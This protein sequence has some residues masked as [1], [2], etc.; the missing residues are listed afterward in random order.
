M[1]K[2]HSSKIMIIGI[3]GM[4]P[5]LTKK[6]MEQGLMPHTQELLRRGAGREDLTMLGGHP[7]ITPPMWTTMA[8]GCY[9]NVHGITC[10]FRESDN[11]LHVHKGYNLH[12]GFCQAELLWNCFVE[13]G[14]K[15]LVYHW[16]G[17]SWPPTSDSPLLHVI[18]GTQP[19][20]VN[21]GIAQVEPEFI[22]QAHVDSTEITF[23][24]KAASDEHIPCVTT[25]MKISETAD[26][27]SNLHDGTLALSV[28]SDGMIDIP[29]TWE[30]GSVI[31]SD[32]PYDV[33][34][35]TLKDASGWSNPIASDAKEFVLLLSH[36]LLR[37]NCLLL[38][39]E[40][41]I[42]DQVAIYKNK[43][44]EEPMIIL[45]NDEYT[46]EI[47]DE[48]IVEDERIQVN[49]N[50]RVLAIDP[51]GNS[52]KIWVSA[53]MKLNED[54]LFHPKKL[55]NIVVD[56]AGNCPPICNIGAGSEKL[57][58][59]CMLKTWDSVNTWNSRAIHAL[60]EAED[61][62]M[63][64]TQMHNIDAV[65]HM[66]LRY[67]N[68]R[69]NSPLPE[70]KYQ[71]LMQQCY[72]DTDKYIGS[73]LHFLDEGWTLFLVSD[74]AQVSSENE[75]VFVNGNGILAELGYAVLKKDENG[76]LL[77]EMDYTQSRA[78]ANRSGHIYISLKGREPYGIV[79]PQD[80]YELEEQ[81]I[82]D[83]YSYRDKKTGKRVI[84]VALRKRDA[85]WF[86][87]GGDYPQSGD[88][89]YFHAEGYNGDHGDCLS[90]S[91]GH[92]DTSVGPI[93]I[94]AGQGIKKN[95][96]TTRIIR[97]IDLVPTIAVLAGVRMPAQT[98]GAPIYQILEE[99]IS[100]L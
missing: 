22:L 63:A 95:T 94:A 84:S 40:A 92:A 82:S 10:Y 50:M 75:R 19:A 20:G 8:T 77:H 38:K 80:Q 18:D 39:N 44:A 36:G 9:A 70:E 15:T 93:F 4:D 14:K 81:I 30:E 57:I 48:A 85:V 12:S 58:R 67:M 16:P 33:V 69:F 1:L 43:K 51:K 59:D 11:L 42:Y 60:I 17:S 2:N 24:A 28:D 31:L 83:L 76:N 29:L 34:I 62:E 41:G 47:I 65:G 49:R 96:L 54:A 100:Q 26:A 25:G 7:T 5:R 74:H 98:E 23:K 13:A 68:T 56:A 89:I 79:E 61:Y 32:Y 78:I 88:I 87:M 45:N 46:E 21:M 27:S 86:G 99:D 6:Y 53:A 52:V 72:V 90:T 55:F 71:E 35:S 97:Q 3:D 91:W 64:F 66:V 73:F 37:R